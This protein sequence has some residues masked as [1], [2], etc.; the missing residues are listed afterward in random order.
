MSPLEMQRKGI[1]K[2]SQE[3]STVSVECSLILKTNR[4]TKQEKKTQTIRE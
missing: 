2:G 3:A 1:G 4:Q